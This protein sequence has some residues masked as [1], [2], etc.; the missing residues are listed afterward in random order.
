[1]HKTLKKIIKLFEFKTKWVNYIFPIKIMN[2]FYYLYVHNNS[3]IFT[4]SFNKKFVSNSNDSIVKKFE[5]ILKF[6]FTSN[7]IVY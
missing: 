3:L 7:I 2:A 6:Y 5:T 4:T 1:M